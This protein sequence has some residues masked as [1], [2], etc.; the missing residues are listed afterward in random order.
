MCRLGNGEVEKAHRHPV[1]VAADYEHGLIPVEPEEG[2]E[3]H[4]EALDA[5]TAAPLVEDAFELRRDW[6]GR[7]ARHQLSPPGNT[8]ESVSHPQ[9]IRRNPRRQVGAVPHVSGPHQFFTTTRR[10]A[11]PTF[12]A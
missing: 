11:R 6:M 1:L 10:V 3:L 12:P 2:V 9:R 5:L 8:A 4:R 7:A